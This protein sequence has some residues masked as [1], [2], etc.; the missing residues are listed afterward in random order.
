MPCALRGLPCT[1]PPAASPMAA[2]HGPGLQEPGLH[3]I[4]DQATEL[5]PPTRSWH[6]RVGCLT[7]TTLT[8][9]APHIRPGSADWAGRRRRPD[10]PNTLP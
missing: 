1:A 9:A 10:R 6:P 7:V 3:V 8:L 5:Q 2:R 4:R